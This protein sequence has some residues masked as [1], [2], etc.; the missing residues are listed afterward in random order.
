[1]SVSEPYNIIT[2]LA[3]RSEDYTEIAIGEMTRVD[4]MRV[5][6]LRKRTKNELVQLYDRA[7]KDETYEPPALSMIRHKGAKLEAL[8]NA[9]RRAGPGTRDYDAILGLINDLG[10]M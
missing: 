4:G 1:M 5:N 9:L 6:D 3:D 2:N 8:K 7:A 10:R